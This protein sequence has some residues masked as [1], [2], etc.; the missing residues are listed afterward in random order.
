MYS[1]QVYELEVC[2][3]RTNSPDRSPNISFKN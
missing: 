2:N 1:R 3:P